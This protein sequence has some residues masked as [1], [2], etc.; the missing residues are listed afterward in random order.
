MMTVAQVLDE[1]AVGFS[2]QILH[3]EAQLLS[4]L[5]EMRKVKAFAALNY[6][7]VFEYCEQRLHL[8]YA[9]C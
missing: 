3:S 1:R 5:I 9:Q 4:V 6:S 7:G 2:K 8:S